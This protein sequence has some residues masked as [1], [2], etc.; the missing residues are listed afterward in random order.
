MHIILRTADSDACPD[1]RVEY[2]AETLVINCKFMVMAY[3]H[4][5]HTHIMMAG[6]QE[7][8]VAETV[9]QVIYSI[10]QEEERNS[11]GGS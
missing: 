4:R 2:T 5:A 7:V 8:L 1:G 9:E 6:G 3:G 11:N 10:E